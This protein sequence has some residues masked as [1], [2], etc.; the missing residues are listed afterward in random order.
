[1]DI[2]V[3]MIHRALIPWLAAATVFGLFLLGEPVDAHTPSQSG[4]TWTC[5]GGDGTNQDAGSCGG[6]T[7]S[8]PPVHHTDASARFWYNASVLANGWTADID[9]GFRAWDQTNGHQFNYTKESSDTANNA[10]VSVTGS[11][12][13]GSS[14]KIGCTAFSQ[15]GGHIN[16]G[17]ATIKFRTNTSAG[18]RADL[19]AHE[20]GHYLGLGHSLNSVVI[21]TMRSVIAEGQQN[22]H[23]Y[24]MNGRCQVYGHSHGLWGGCSH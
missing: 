19:A 3:P 22:L 4:W 20:F 8:N 16:E 9:I 7:V 10:N 1:M 23:S 5:V 2:R 21:P 17:G 14:S 24:D 11:V 6:M 18:L 12:I 13:C 15:T